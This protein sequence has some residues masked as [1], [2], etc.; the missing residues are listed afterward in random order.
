M[1]LQNKIIN[2]VGI[3]RILHFAFGGWLACLAP[4]WYYA[5]LIVFTIGRLKELSDKYIKKSVFDVWD[6]VATLAGS[7]VTAI[8]YLLCI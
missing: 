1:D 7:A 4:S 2:K 5:L 8:V 3:D 6:W